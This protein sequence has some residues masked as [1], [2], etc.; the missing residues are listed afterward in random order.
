MQ[1]ADSPGDWRG[2]MVTPSQ[3]ELRQS[4]TKEDHP[5]QFKERCQG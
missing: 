5:E 3:E 4:S 1:A 2:M